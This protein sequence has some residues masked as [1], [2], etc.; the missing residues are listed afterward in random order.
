[1]K[2]NKAS[3]EAFEEI[4]NALEVIEQSYTAEEMADALFALARQYDAR[5]TENE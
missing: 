3:K 4:D 2:L 5:V 1:M